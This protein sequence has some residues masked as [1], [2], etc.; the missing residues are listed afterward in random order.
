MKSN[1]VQKLILFAFL[2]LII[3][4]C[5]LGNRKCPLEFNS[6]RIRIVNSTNGNDLVFGS[7]RIYDKN[8]IVFYSLNGLDTIFHHYNPGPNTNPGQDSLLFVDFDYRNYETVFLRL[9]NSEIDTLHL[10][11]QLIHAS[12]CCDDYLSVK[13]NRFNNEPLE[14]LDGGIT[15]IRK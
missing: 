15:L 11:Y 3:I 1:F 14:M 2:P 10:N 12:A 4:S 8:F 6:A 9:T 13:L 7:T 5:C